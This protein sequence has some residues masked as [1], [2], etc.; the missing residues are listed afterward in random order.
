M[1][2]IQDYREPDIAIND[3][4]CPNC[5]SS[6]HARCCGYCGIKYTA[7]MFKRRGED[8]FC[9]AKCERSQ[10]TD[11]E[12]SRAIEGGVQTARLTAATRRGLCAL[13]SLG[14]VTADN[15][16]DMSAPRRKNQ[17]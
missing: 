6:L 5:N 9:S 17:P 11:N 10:H 15:G 13:R 14:D 4:L 8:E 16:Q 3:E 12:R 2:Q 7:A 1:I